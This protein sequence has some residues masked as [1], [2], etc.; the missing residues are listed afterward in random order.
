MFSDV[1]QG[2]QNNAALGKHHPDASQ[3][4]RNL[5]LCRYQSQNYTEA[6]E[7]LEETENMMIESL[8][9]EHPH[10][11]VRMQNL[12]VT[13]YILENIEKAIELT[14]RVL[15]I[16]QHALKH[17]PDSKRIVDIRTAVLQKADTV[18]V[19]HADQIISWFKDRIDFG[20]FNH[21]E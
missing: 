12:A 6:A 3:A 10:T 18:G 20:H 8:R 2:L 7:M 21:N 14:D 15:A 16:R 4:R 13:Y 11:L 9:E 19:T 5:A 17:H 1:I